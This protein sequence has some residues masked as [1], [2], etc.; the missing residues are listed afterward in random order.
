MH[1]P[2]HNPLP[3]SMPARAG[4]HQKSNADFEDALC[5]AKRENMALTS[6]P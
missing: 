4:I 1:V 6:F 3:A 5:S 2:N